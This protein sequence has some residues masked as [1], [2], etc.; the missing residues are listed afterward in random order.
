[1]DL[2]PEPEK[3]HLVV[4][5][6]GQAQEVSAAK[7][8]EAL[9]Q[10]IAHYLPED[11]KAINRANNHGVSVVIEAPSARFFKSLARLSKTQRLIDQI[12]L[13]VRTINCLDRHG[14]SS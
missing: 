10:A 14:S 2:P 13:W 1:L 9:G 6:Y 11:A 12:P 8:E 4:N 7:A 3:V 5:R